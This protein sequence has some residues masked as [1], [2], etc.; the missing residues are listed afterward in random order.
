MKSYAFSTKQAYLLLVLG[1]YIFYF[2]ILAVKIQIP[3]KNYFLA[4]FLL[5]FVSSASYAQRDIFGKWKTVDDETG[6][7]K[8]VVEIFEKD[9]K[10]Y[11]KIIKL[12][13]KPHQDQNPLCDECEGDKKD[14][15]ILG[16]TIITAMEYDAEDDEWENGEILDP[17]DGDIYSLK[18][19]REGEKLKVR[20]YIAFFFRT[21]TWLPYKE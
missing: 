12:N 14:Q 13:R 21:Q 2:S 16:M 5:L 6:E 15:P 1:S 8:S 17:S 9:G 18:L 10:A 19:W 7:V 3:M 11:G 20:G 4:F